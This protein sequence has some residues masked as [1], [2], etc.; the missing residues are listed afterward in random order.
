MP[1]FVLVKLIVSL[2]LT[3]S[4]V[5]MFLLSGNYVFLV[6]PCPVS[7]SSTSFTY[8]MSLFSCLTSHC[9]CLDVLI[10]VREGDDLNYVLVL[11]LLVFCHIFIACML[12]FVIF[13]V[14]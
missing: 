2:H 4:S 13:S 12:E 14:S 10:F 9:L 11:Y 3:P 7:F 6:T 5:F 1:V 8:D